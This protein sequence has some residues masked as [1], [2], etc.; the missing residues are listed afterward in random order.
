MYVP[1]TKPKRPKTMRNTFLHSFQLHLPKS[2]Q[3]TAVSIRAG[4]I[5]PKNDKH[6]EPNKEMKS[7][8]FGIATA[9]PTISKEKILTCYI[10]GTKKY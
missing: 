9:S 2:P 1:V 3:N 5:N 4:A 8:K 6:R 10:K 7:S